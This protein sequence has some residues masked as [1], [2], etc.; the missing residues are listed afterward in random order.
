MTI[1]WWEP[2]VV[3]L[4]SLDMSRSSKGGYM[5]P[6]YGQITFAP[7]TYTGEPPRKASVNLNWGLNYDSSIKIFNGTIMLRK[8]TT[9]EL[10]YDIFEPEMETKLLEEGVNTED[11]DVDLPLI[12]G[13]ITHMSPQRTGNESER[14]YYFPDFAGSIGN[15]VNAYDDGV[16]INDSWVANGDGTV[17]RSVDLVGELTFSGLGNKSG[18][19][20]FFSW[21]CDELGLSLNSD[22]A[23]DVNLDC[24]ITSQQYIIDF[25]DKIAWY[26][27]HGFYILGNILYLVQNNA[28]NGIQEVSLST[29]DISPVKFTYNWPQPIKKYSAAWTTRYAETDVDGS[30]V[31]SENH[32][33]EVFNDF[34]VIGIEESLSRVY[35]ESKSEVEN[36]LQDIIERENM[37]TIVIELPLFRLPR[38]GERIN[39]RDEISVNPV[40]GYVYCR[41]FNLNYAAKTVIIEGDGEVTFT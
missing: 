31:E 38:Y 13:S 33:V 26:C 34:S 41:K 39:F 3:D 25:L 12:V 20:G 29:G 24:V 15:G 37:P 36:K 27:D 17:S 32:E 11:S 16:I 30:R 5:K 8:Y 21:A 35:N 6:S 28:T 1:V 22:L 14:R 9:Q 10:I 23:E 7:D 18:I 19:V 40:E 2:K 4:P